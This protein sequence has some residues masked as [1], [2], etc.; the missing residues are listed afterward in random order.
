MPRFAQVVAKSNLIQLDREFDFVIPEQMQGQI[1]IGQQVSFPFGRSKKLQTGFVVGLSDQ[2]DYATSEIAE[3][4]HP[5]IALSRE[6]FE[7][8]RLV[9]DR[10]CVALGEV[11]SAAIPD[12]M[13][14]TA[15]P[16][17]R[18][19]TPPKPVSNHIEVSPDFTLR[20]AVLSSGRAIE[21]SGALHSDWAV[22]AA[23]AAAKTLAKGS[24]VIVCLPEQEDI[25]EFG[26][27]IEYFG[28]SDFLIK[29]SP[30]QK[31]SERF[32][33]FHQ[34]LGQNL[35]LV[36]GTRS[37]IYA[38]ARNLGLVVV[39][40]D[41][42]DSLREPGSPYTHVRELALM[43]AGGSCQL[44]FVAP[45]RSV[46]I[47]RLV[48]IGYLT[49][50][51]TKL[52]PPRIAF[53]EPSLRFDDSGYSLVRERLEFGPVLILLPRKGSSASLYCGSC[54]ERLRCSCGGMIW[55][56]SEHKAA[57]RICNKPHISC[58]KCKSQSIRR[59]RTGSERTVSE[60]GKT[61]PN[62]AI[63]EATAEK[64]PGVLK[65]KRQIVVATPSA[66]PRV[67]GGYAGIL[68]L[69]A[70]IWL[71]RQSLNAENFAIRDWMSAIELLAPDGRV[72]LSGVDKELGQ[73]FSMQQHRLLAKSQLKELRSLGLPPANRIASVQTEPENIDA[74]I[75][76]A[77]QANA[78]LLRV[79]AETGTALFSFGYQD[80]AKF[81]KAL[82]ALAL[83][84]S[85]RVQGGAKRRGVRIVMDDPNAL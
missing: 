79:E 14:R 19:L 67:Q 68:I 17:P 24:S 75:E 70:D 37:A 38:P 46:E 18:E 26:R 7:F 10:Q 6:L 69:D 42:D 54:G 31:R 2:S 39:Y 84:T 28:L 77:R 53:S 55:E 51:D 76:A 25:A 33:A 66:A 72:L 8:C 27:A 82:R 34:I 63:A 60:L 83:K 85:A 9:A 52:P 50:H 5:A 41:L 64:R 49:D 32:Q 11:L 15:V 59:G 12:H 45:Y 36:V 43:R 40:D 3:I 13:A 73:A 29:L 21:L 47:Q 48:E 22:L 62:V 57:C 35:S 1:A 30:G 81:S 78:K 23:Q 74:V 4:L 56:P 61:F 71:S 65:A 44:L 20:S 16:E 58:S 80:G